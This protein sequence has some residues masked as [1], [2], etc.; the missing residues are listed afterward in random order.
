[1][2]VPVFRENLLRVRYESVTRYLAQYTE[3]AMKWMQQR[4]KEYSQ[5]SLRSLVRLVEKLSCD[6]HTFRIQVI[7]EDPFRCD[8]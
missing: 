2:L 4:V 3:L 6:S 7:V 5:P 8:S 1:M